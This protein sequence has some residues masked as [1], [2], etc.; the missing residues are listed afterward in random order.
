MFFILHVLLMVTATLG[1]IAGVIVAMFFR[2]NGTWLKSH[3][4]LN[5][6][7]LVGIAGGIIMAFI[8][9]ADSSGKHIDGFHQINGLAAFIIASCTMFAGFYQ[10]KAKNKSAVRAAHRW[11]GRISLLMFLT[12]II[13]GL[14]LINII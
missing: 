14:L 9:V 13:L 3:K 6:F 2:K 7:S 11:L 8:Y 12:A 4:T 1:F 10:F 5:S